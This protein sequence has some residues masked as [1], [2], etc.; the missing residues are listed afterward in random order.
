MQQ[1]TKQQVAREIAADYAGGVT[2][3]QLELD[4]L[5]AIEHFSQLALR[6]RLLSSKTHKQTEQR[7]KEFAVQLA[8]A[9][10]SRSVLDIIRFVYHEGRNNVRAEMPDEF[11]VKA[12]S[13]KHIKELI[14]LLRR[15]PVRGDSTQPISSVKSFKKGGVRGA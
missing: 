13:H 8:A 14:R 5:M 11:F 9:K 1:R 7:F 2:R 3:K 15:L 12:T 6:G 4:I 10:S